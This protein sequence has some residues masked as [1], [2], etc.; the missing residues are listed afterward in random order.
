MDN[1]EN[2]NINNNENKSDVKT[3]STKG[4]LWKTATVGALAGILGGGASYYGMSQLT[5]ANVPSVSVSKD[6]ASVSNVSTKSAGTMTSA[7]NKVNGAVVSVI[8]LQTQ[9]SSTDFFGNQQQTQGDNDA[10]SGSSENSDD[11][12]SSSSGTLQTYS[13]GSGVIYLKSDGKAYIVTNNHVVS[14]SDEINVIL[15]S[16]KTL[17]AKIVGTDSETDLAVLSIDAS[18]VTTVASFGESKNLQPGQS[19][20]AIGSPLGSEYATSVTQGIVSAK[21]RTVNITDNYGNV[22]NQ[23][24]VIQ[25]DAA[26]NPGNSGGPLVNASG[27]VVG[28]NSMKLSTST[29]GS[30]VEGMG[31]A[32]PSDEVVTIINQLVKK[33]KVSRPQLGVSIGGVSE[34]T[35]NRRSQLNLPDSINYGVF[36]ASVTKNS[37]AS[38]AGLK[39]KDVIVAMDGKKVEDVV[40]LHSNLYSHKI[41]DKVSVE[42][43]RDGKK[44][45]V[46]VT[47]K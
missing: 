21:S 7:F 18:D 8:N 14:G 38:N 17:S 24:T 42:I 40:S 3:K 4:I 31:F 41:G 37:A 11:S 47:L 6:Y 13:E 26:I 33:G 45:T 28:I 27:Q 12:N 35:T 10:T 2:N 1:N 39:A 5:T 15:S 34:L 23:T 30:T 19:V 9:N 20:I 29:D 25:T 22:T 36:I 46:S 44:Q 43:Y 16:G 32:I